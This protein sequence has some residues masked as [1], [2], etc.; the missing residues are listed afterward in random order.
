MNDESLKLYKAIQEDIKEIFQMALKN[1]NLQDSNL[2]KSLKVEVNKNSDIFKILFNDYIEYIEEGRKPKAK[3]VP[4]RNLIE[5]CKRKGIKSDNNTV[6]AI[7]QS[8]YLYGIPK[9]PIFNY[10]NK[11][12]DL[13]WNQKW[14]DDI[15]K[16]I[17]NKIKL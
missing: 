13:Y 17:I 7:Q 8:I 11:N 16:E 2:Y 6:Y 10:I 3:K 14:S 9:R 15:F 5:W 12:I 1:I 4:I